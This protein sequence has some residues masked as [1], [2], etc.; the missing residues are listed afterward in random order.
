MGNK[1]EFNPDYIVPPGETLEELL[2]H[3]DMT[4]AE[5]AERT[6]RTPKLINEIIKGK[7][8]LTPETGLQL[9]RVFGVEA[10][11]WNNLESNYRELLARKKSE[12][13]LAEQKDFLRKFPV[14]FMTNNGWIKAEKDKLKQLEE[15]LSF[16]GV[17]SFDAWKE[18]WEELLNQPEAAFR[19]TKSFS[20]STE[21]I[22]VWLR[23]GEIEARGIQCA[24]YNEKKFKESLKE[25][26]QLSDEDPEIFVPKLTKACAKAGVAVVFV[27]ETPTSRVSGATTWSGKRPIII[28]SFRYK[29][30][31]HLWFTF[32]HEAGHILK[33][34]KKITFLEFKDNVDEFEEEANH[35]ASDIL[36]PP[37]DYQGFI[38]KRDFSEQAITTFAEEVKIAPGVVVGRLQHDGY[39]PYPTKL[40]Y[41]KKSYK[42][43]N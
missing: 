30:N 29:S 39:I 42:W 6:G 40:N 24:P 27:P 25:I 16:F 32:F 19:K 1:N 20:A 28:L 7:A 11:F 35:F 21:S 10:E 4:Q 43:F 15:L 12:E 22:A 37:K 3:Y 8:S 23:K 41:L 34:S 2:E 33:H 18:V 26:K 9:E 14:K 13:Q 17:A 5:L 38:K 31:D 36:I